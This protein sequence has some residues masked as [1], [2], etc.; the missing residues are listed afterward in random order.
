MTRLEESLEKIQL[1]RNEL[2]DADHKVLVI[3]KQ[4]NFAWVTAG[5]RSFIGLASE[6][7]CVSLV[8][9]E[10]EVYLAGN[11]IEVPRLIAEELPD[12]LCQPF[13]LPW[14]EDFTL[15][16]VIRKHFGEFYTDQ[17]K[18]GWFKEK[19]MILNPNE[20]DRYREIGKLT[21]QAVEKSCMQAV[22]SMTEFQLG[23]LVSAGLWAAGLEPIT[24]LV[25]GDTRSQRVRH[26]VPTDQTLDSGAIVS[27][28]ARA[29]GLVVSCT[30]TV[31]F[32]DDFASK[33]RQLLNVEQDIFEST[34][35]GASLH[36]ILETAKKSY[37]ANQLDKEWM[38]HHQGGLTG[39]MARE[40]RVD[41]ETKG[42]ASVGNA[43][44]WNPSAVGCK[45]EDTFLL[46]SDGPEILTPVSTPWPTVQKGRF[47]RPDILRK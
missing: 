11:N 38:N 33:Y 29:F 21:A 27:V 37:T 2:F 18:A 31:A 41:S 45:C 43:F 34:M 39:Y 25:A 14:A 12:N 47:T 28:C 26:Y 6:N 7:A 35:P 40:I 22:P 10:N 46:T 4:N 5:A 15:A 20:C 13:A 17:E 23:G 9:T 3:Q 16:S 1:I 42:C 44:A 32:T 36:D 19:R 8:I 30:R 24:I